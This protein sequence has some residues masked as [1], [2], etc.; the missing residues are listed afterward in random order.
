MRRSLAVGA[1]V[2]LGSSP[3]LA[4]QNLAGK[5]NLA[6]VAGRPVP[7]AMSEPGRPADAPP[8]PTVVAGIFSI[9]SAGSFRLAM[10]YRIKRDT[11]ER[12]ISRE[13]TGS[14]TRSGAGWD[15][16]W[17][18]AG[19]TPVTLSGDTLTMNNEGVAFV[20]LRQR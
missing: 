12:T 20:Y 6:T 5:Y 19:T 8:P 7:V 14:Y 4:Q 1:L 10:T 18:G 3:C 11:T 13:F 2:L 16:Q 9:D 17:T 15:F